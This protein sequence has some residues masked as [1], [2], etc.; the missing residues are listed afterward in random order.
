MVWLLEDFSRNKFFWLQN[1]GIFREYLKLLSYD[2]HRTST[3][4][5]LIHISSFSSCFIPIAIFD[6]KS[7]HRKE[8]KKEHEERS[9][10]NTRVN[11]KKHLRK[12]KIPLLLSCISLFEK[13]VVLCGA[14]RWNGVGN[15][16]KRSYR[17]YPMR[18]V[19]Y[20]GKLFPKKACRL[21]DRC[22]L[23]YC[24]CSTILLNWFARNVG[25]LELPLSRSE[26]TCHPFISN[27]D[28]SAI[29]GV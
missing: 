10:W 26:S 17:Y 24:F 13:F 4:M 22:W 16:Q 28:L 29:W 3:F 21:H 20:Y 14:S 7:Q 12:K 2:N 5:H 11:E 9:K 23:F 8:E 27:I 1:F 19:C 15:W 25:G 6:L 18:G